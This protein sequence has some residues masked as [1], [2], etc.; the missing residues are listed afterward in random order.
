MGTQRNKVVFAVLPTAVT[1]LV[2][3][4]ENISTLQS[5]QLGFFDADTSLAF[6][7]GT[8]VIPKNILVALGKGAANG[9]PMIDFRHSAGQEIQLQG[10]RTY[11]RKNYTA[12]SPMVV[13]ISGITGGSCETNYGLRVN[14][15]NDHILK[16][17]GFNMFNQNLYIKTGCCECESG[18]ATYDGNLIVNLFLAEAAKNSNN[19][20]V[21]EGYATSDLTMLTHGTSAN[22]SAGDIMTT[23]DIAA[24]V[25]FNAAQPDDT[26][27]V[28]AGLQLTSVPEKIK[29][30]CQISLDY[31]KL[32]ETSLQVSLLDGF[33]CSGATVTTTDL[34][35]SEGNGKNVMHKEYL[36]SGWTGSG[37]YLQSAVTGLAFNNIEYLAKADT[38][39]T[40]FYLEYDVFA[41]GGM[42]DYSNP[43]RTII[44]I[45]TAN[46]ALITAVETILQAIVAN[47]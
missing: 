20:Y 6:D 44:A 24:L 13:N 45:P 38:N 16:Q 18:C 7:E 9:D 8:A 29:A 3:E 11:T 21:I 40:Q 19:Y 1:T 32:L 41:G 23:E 25:V 42:L 35:Y 4:G 10:V 27:K 33:A 12:G 39:Y 31:H 36:S 28:Y 47:S 34:V 46:T 43:L 15:S 2:A 26:T 17:I 30:Y 37:P 5:G 22:Y 14:V